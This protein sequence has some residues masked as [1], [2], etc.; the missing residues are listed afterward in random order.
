ML[1]RVLNKEF[2]KSIKLIFIKT[3]KFF[4]ARKFHLPKYDK[5]FQTLLFSRFNITRKKG[6]KSIRNWGK[7]KEAGVVKYK[8]FFNFRTRNF[9]SKSLREYK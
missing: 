5:F 6:L 4:R 9:F 2:I 8:K 3:I 1:L 7:K